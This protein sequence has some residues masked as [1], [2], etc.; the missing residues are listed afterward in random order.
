MQWQRAQQI[1][2]IF[3]LWRKC[4]SAIPSLSHHMVTGSLI[5]DLCPIRNTILYMM[6]QYNQNHTKKHACNV[7]LSTS[8][9]SSSSSSSPSSLSSSSPSSSSSSSSSSPPPPSSSSSVSSSPSSS[10]SS[11]SSSSPSSSVSSTSSLSTPS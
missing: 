3:Y 11:S 1:T 10:S 5:N 9:S 4:H 7:C 2:P 6:F 8:S